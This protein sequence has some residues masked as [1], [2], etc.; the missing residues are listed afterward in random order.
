MTTWA[1]IVNGV[2]RDIVGGDEEGPHIAA[3][4]NPNGVAWT[5]VPDG[6]LSGATSNGDGTFTNPTPIAA[7]PRI[8]TKT[9][10]QDYVVSQL[11]GSTAGMARFTAIMDATQNSASGAVR[12][13]YARYEAALTF[14]KSNT[15]SLTAIMAADTQTG[16]ITSDER[17]AILNNWPLV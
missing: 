16:H 11:G 5:I 1:Q 3:G 12:F 14:E 4:Y 15:A 2:A 10:F 7:E 13:A 6:T 17:S 9:A 8:L